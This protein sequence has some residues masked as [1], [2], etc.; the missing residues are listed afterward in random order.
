MMKEMMEM[1][2][3]Y[4]SGSIVAFT[5]LTPL[6]ALVGSLAL[7]FAKEPSWGDFRQILLVF[8]ALVGAVWWFWDAL[9]TADDA[10]SLSVV[11]IAAPIFTWINHHNRRDASTRDSRAAGL[12]SIIA[13]ASSLT[14]RS[15][16]G[17]ALLVLAAAAAALW[18]GT[19]KNSQRVSFMK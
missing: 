4:P 3:N 9:I 1:M 11:T 8:A 6:C 14:L 12:T 17:I 15:G 19:Q 2:Q 18:F 5:V 16:I 13:V 7:S 10:V